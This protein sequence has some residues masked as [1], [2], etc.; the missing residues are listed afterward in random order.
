M[1]RLGKYLW[2]F[3]DRKYSIIYDNRKEIKWGQQLLVLLEYGILIVPSVS[4][5]SLLIKTLKMS[6]LRKGVLI[7]AW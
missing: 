7:T 4:P 2:A 5:N 6:L 1:W 3:K